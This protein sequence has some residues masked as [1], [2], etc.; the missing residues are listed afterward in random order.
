VSP[1][2][3]PSAHAAGSG[4]RR[5]RGLDAEQRREQRREQLLEAALELFAQ[6]GYANTSIEQICQRAYVGTKGFYELF[7]SKEHCYRAL[8]TELTVRAKQAMDEAWEEMPDDEAAATEHLVRAFAHAI[9]DDTRVALVLFGYARGIS[10]EIET[11]RRANRRY[12]AGYVVRLWERFDGAARAG[13]AREP[14]ALALIGG[15]FELIADWIL[16]AD[17]ADAAE[18]ERLMLQ[19]GRF[20]AVVRAGLGK[21]SRRRRRGTGGPAAS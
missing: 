10:Q 21:P 20:A 4:S 5:I 1:S 16:D 6:N 8:L 11:V 12:A 19:M 18:R 14:V 2:P 17:P 9:V 7:E 3:S 15:L 13:D